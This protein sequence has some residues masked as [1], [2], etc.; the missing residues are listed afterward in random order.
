MKFASLVAGAAGL[1]LLVTTP[2]SAQV[3]APVPDSVQALMAEFQQL[4]AQVQQAQMQAVQTNPELQAEQQKIQETVENAMTE[5]DPAMG[6]KLDSLGQ[7]QQEAAA[8]QEASDTERL[9]TIM[10]TGQR[11]QTQV[12]AAQQQ[13][14]EQEEVAREVEAFQE[15]LMGVIQASNPEITGVIERLEELSARLDSI[16]DGGGFEGR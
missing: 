12:Q 13:A 10:A 11:L 8:A 3:T 2:A 14:L 16:R 6:A 5:A 7:L 4:N 9:Q 15:D 1:A